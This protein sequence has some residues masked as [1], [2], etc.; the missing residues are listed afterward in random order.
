GF[1]LVAVGILLSTLGFMLFFNRSL[2]GTGNLTTILGVVLIAGK[3]RASN[4]MFRWERA[5]GTSIF[6]LGVYFVLR[7]R[8]RLGVM[9]ELFGILNLFGNFIPSLLNLIKKLPV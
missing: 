5:R 3:K 1:V 4:F 8:A 9:I 6:L 2:I 7:G